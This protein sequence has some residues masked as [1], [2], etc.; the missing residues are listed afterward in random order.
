MIS[1]FYI[2]TTISLV[3]ILA[4]GILSW[5]LSSIQLLVIGISCVILIH[6]S[7][8]V[9]GMFSIRSNFFFK[10]IKGK[11]FFENKNGILFRFDDGPNPIYTPQILDIL[12]A[13]GIRALFAVTGKNAEQY[14]EIVER[15]F[16]ENHIIANHT[17]THPLNILF[18]GYHKVRDEIIRT[19][20]IIQRITGEQPKYF[21]SPIGHKNPV[22][23]RVI[24]EVGMI[25]VM[26]DIRTFGEY[27]SGSVHHQIETKFRFYSRRTPCL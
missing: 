26:W 15:I 7:F 11:E 3:S 13:E 19:N 2:T 5:F 20:S 22:I 18:L 23:G 21:C 14:P 17:Y 6:Q 8:F 10:T 4:I 27:R 9:Y 25:P 12:K 24:K 1:K 16:R